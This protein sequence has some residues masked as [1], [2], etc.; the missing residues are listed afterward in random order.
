MERLTNENAMKDF[1][2]FRKMVNEK[3][4]NMFDG[5]IDKEGFDSVI[6]QTENRLKEVNTEL[7]TRRLEESHDVLTGRVKDPY[8]YAD[9]WWTNSW[10]FNKLVPTPMKNV[11]QDRNI[12]TPIKK[13]FVKNFM[14]RVCY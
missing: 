2:E 12:V 14:T 9:S 13:F 7:T 4:Q 3:Q 1:I 10:I 5:P 11:L 8:R 6:Q